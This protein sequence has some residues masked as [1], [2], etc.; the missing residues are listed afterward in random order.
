MADL[1]PYRIDYLAYQ[2]KITNKILFLIFLAL[3]IPKIIDLIIYIY[4][5][6]RNKKNWLI[7]KSN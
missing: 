2:L 4:K 7:V 3:V 6:F 1:I 5:S